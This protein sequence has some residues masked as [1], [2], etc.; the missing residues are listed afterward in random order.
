MREYLFEYAF[1]GAEWSLT[2]EADSESEAVARV[3]AMSAAI[4]LGQ[5]EERIPART[6]FR[7]RAV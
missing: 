1:A 3:R 5:L 2:V 4:L 7:P 6:V